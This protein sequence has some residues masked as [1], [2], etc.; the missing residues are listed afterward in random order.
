MTTKVGAFF[1]YPAKYKSAI[2]RK[3]AIEKYTI[4]QKEI[5]MEEQKEVDDDIVKSLTKDSSSKN[6]DLYRFADGDTVG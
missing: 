3:A 5:S 2:Q 4:E 1:P 6:I